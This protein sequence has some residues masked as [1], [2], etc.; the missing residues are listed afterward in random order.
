LSGRFGDECIFFDYDTIEGGDHF[1]KRLRQGVEECAVL[2][3]LIRPAWL[4]I[5]GAATA[6]CFSAMPHQ[7]SKVSTWPVYQRR[8]SMTPA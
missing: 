4:D 3:A 6:P 5:T 1:P 7:R 2:L 8:L